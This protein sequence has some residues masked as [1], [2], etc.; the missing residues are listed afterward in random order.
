MNVPDPADLEATV[1]AALGA[2]CSV[3]IDFV[4]IDEV[5]RSIEALGDAY[6]DRLFTAQERASCIGSPRARAASFAARF[7]AKEAALKVLAP[8]GP[9]PEW[10]SIEVV[11]LPH[12]ACELHLHGT[13][14]ALADA[15]GLRGFSVSL[16]HEG[17]LAAAV[18]VGEC[19]AQ[20][21]SITRLDGRDDHNGP[22]ENGGTDGPRHRGPSP[23]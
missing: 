16:T 6:L 8:T 13:A 20:A 22:P 1:Q 18:V 12:G 9:R 15:A 21:A 3:G 2:H 23:R 19:P 5:A 11:R 14:A 7:A 10:R 4:D 17:G